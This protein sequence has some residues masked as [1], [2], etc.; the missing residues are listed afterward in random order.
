MGTRRRFLASTAAL[1][2]SALLPVPAAAQAAV[3]HEAFGEVWLD[4]TRFERASA[5]APGSLLATGADGRLWF[6]LGGDAYYLRPHTRLRLEPPGLGERVVSAMRLLTGALSATFARGGARRV[7]ARNVTIGIR[8]TGIHLQTS[9]HAIYA[10]TC[11]GTTE[12]RTANASQEV[13][14]EHHAGRWIL[15]DGRVTPTT[16][17]RGH[18]DEE[19]VRLERLAARPDPFRR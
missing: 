2:S 17:M 19:I 7:I 8:G 12:L 13:R 18:G 1:A 5:I 9:P 3:V 15:D 11:F 6:T 4:G 10:C 14:A 16:E